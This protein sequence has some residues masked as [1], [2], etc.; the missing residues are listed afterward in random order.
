[1][2]KGMKHLIGLL[3]CLIVL[4]LVLTVAIVVIFVQKNTFACDAKDNTDDQYECLS[5]AMTTSDW[6]FANSIDALVDKK[7]EDGDGEGAIDLLSDWAD[8]L[9]L[10]EKCDTLVQMVNTNKVDKLSPDDLFDYYTLIK[11]NLSACDKKEAVSEIEKKQN[12][13][14]ESG[15][16]TKPKAH[17]DI[18]G[19]DTTDDDMTDDELVVEDEDE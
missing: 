14:E 18:W 17:V 2:K 3:G 11:E 5:Q 13:L 12:D 7:I 8:T 1:M 4:I 10:E 15:R 6:A 9:V 16:M 19:G